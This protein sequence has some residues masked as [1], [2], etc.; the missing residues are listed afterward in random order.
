[1]LSSSQQRKRPTRFDRPSTSTSPILNHAIATAPIQMAGT[2]LPR[3]SV[4]ED[5]PYV[6][7]DIIAEPRPDIKTIR[8]QLMTS[9]LQQVMTTGTDAPPAPYHN[10][11]ERGDDVT[12]DPSF[13]QSS[14]AQSRSSPNAEAQAPRT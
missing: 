7:D 11:L 10:Q 6:P 12:L 4:I 5:D 1:M 14:S 2:R 3:Q 9:V 13:A 8:D